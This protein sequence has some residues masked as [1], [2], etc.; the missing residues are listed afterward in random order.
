MTIGCNDEIVMLP[1]SSFFGPD[2]DIARCILDRREE[3]ISRD[4][5]VPLFVAAPMVRYSKLPFRRL[6]GMYGADV[7]YTPMIYASNFCAS[8]KCRRSEFT[9]DS[10]DSPVVQFAVNEPK[11]FADATELVYPWS[12]GVDIN[13]GCPKRDVTSAGFGSHLLDN[14]DLIADMVAQARSRIS[15]PTYSISVK[16]RIQ[17]PLEKT[18]DLCRKMEKA[19]VTRLAVHGRTRYMPNDPVDKEAIALVKSSVGVSI[20]ANGGVTTFAE[21]LE[22]AKETKVDGIMVANGLLSNPAMFGGH[23]VTPLQCITDFVN[24]EASK[25]LHFDIF[26]QQLIFMLRPILSAPQ[27]RFFNELTSVAAVKDF[28]VDEIGCI[29]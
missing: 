20:F 16:I 22:M 21:A 11:V 3:C 24:L 18:I 19:G 1:S 27:R 28:L 6:V 13:C 12:S 9:T 14:P 7:I 25:S 29:L 23:D 17:Y 10:V 8:E 5:P 15:D 2:R 4:M 26:H